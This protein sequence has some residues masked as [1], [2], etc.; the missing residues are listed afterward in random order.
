[1]NDH[2]DTL[3]TRS[4]AEREAAQ[5][6]ALP[7]QIAHAQRHSAAFADILKGVDAASVNSR[8]ALARLPVTRKSELLERQKATRAQGGDP[9]GGFA[10]LVRGPG[11][12]RVFASPGPI[13][14]PE[15]A[16]RDYWRSG[17]ALF[18]AGF[19]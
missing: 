4:P 7:S 3:E 14:E 16:G 10:A 12:S 18:A 1:M 9:F 11:M 8:A 15:G 17:R 13:Y 5:M 2:F 19:R 6:A